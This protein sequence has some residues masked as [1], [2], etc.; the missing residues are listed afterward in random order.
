MKATHETYHGKAGA[1]GAILSDLEHLACRENV[2][3]SCNDAA[4]MFS[5][6]Q[7]MASR[8]QEI[9]DSI[10]HDATAAQKAEATS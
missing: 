10:Q 7:I 2:N 1:I 8:A 5:A 9:A 6:I 3:T 4:A